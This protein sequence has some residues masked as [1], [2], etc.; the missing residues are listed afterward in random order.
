MKIFLKMKKEFLKI[1]RFFLPKTKTIDR[2]KELDKARKIIEKMSS[3]INKA[4][5]YSALYERVALTVDGDIENAFDNSYEAW[6]LKFSSEAL[7][8][9]LVMALMRIVYGDTENTASLLNLMKILKKRGV[10]K[11]LEEESD[12]H[13]QR[14]PC[15]L[16]Q[17]E[18][19]VNQVKGKH[20]LKQINTHRN[21]NIAHQVIDH[22]PKKHKM[23]K[24]EDPSKFLEELIPVVVLCRSLLRDPSSNETDYE[25]KINAEIWMAKKMANEFWGYA[26]HIRNKLSGTED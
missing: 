18:K 3:N 1:I 25:I 22:D 26:A 14:L 12:E 6:G 24:Y 9:A 8:D 15:G 5:W 10:F 2:K 17:L 20:R 11:L 7:L 19:K 23:P 21:T 13:N 16:D 4:I